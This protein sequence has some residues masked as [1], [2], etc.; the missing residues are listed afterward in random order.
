MMNEKKMQEA[1][2][3]ANGNVLNRFDHY[4]AVAYILAEAGFLCAWLHTVQGRQHG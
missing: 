3:N 2:Q 4:Q 1:R